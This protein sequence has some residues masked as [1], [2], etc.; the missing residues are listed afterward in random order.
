MGTRDGYRIR[1]PKLPKFSDT[2][3]SI[4]YVGSDTGTTRILNFRIRVGYGIVVTRQLPEYSGSDTGKIQ[5]GTRLAVQYRRAHQQC[6][7]CAAMLPAR[8]I[9]VVVV[10]LGLLDLSWAG[11]YTNERQVSLLLAVVLLSQA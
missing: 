3:T 11:R 7:S 9:A 10:R 8:P 1:V 6:C 2:D 5:S 4:F